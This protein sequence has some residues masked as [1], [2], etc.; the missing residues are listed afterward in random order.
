MYAASLVCNAKRTLIPKTWVRQ[1]EWCWKNFKVTNSRLLKADFHETGPEVRHIYYVLQYAKL[2]LPFCIMTCRCIV[3]LYGSRHIIH[4]RG[5]S[6]KK[7][8]FLD[9]LSEILTEHTS[10]QE[11]KQLCYQVSAVFIRVTVVRSLI[12]HLIPFFFVDIIPKLSCQVAKNP[13]SN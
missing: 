6:A 5:I 9:N 8:L 7:G 10:Q 1:R 13:R 3:Q 12:V 2:S 11:T 4:K